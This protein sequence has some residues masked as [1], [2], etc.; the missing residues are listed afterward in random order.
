MPDLLPV[1]PDSDDD[2]NNSDSTGTSLGDDA[3]DEDEDDWDLDEDFPCPHTNHPLHWMRPTV[4]EMYDQ[5]YK[6]PWD[7]FPRG[8]AY[9]RHVLGVMKDTCPDLFRQELCMSHTTIDRLVKK[10]A[11]DPVFVNGSNNAQMPVKDQLAITLF[12]FGH[13]GNAAGLQKVATGVGGANGTISLVTRRIMTA[14]PPRVHVG[15]CSH[16]DRIR[17]GECEGAGSVAFMQRVEEWMVHGRRYT[18]GSF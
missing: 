14:V 1:D 11:D 17:E 2:D 4:K 9:L 13:S 8:P 6:M 18:G 15:G 5:R 7:T 12:R 16:A 10:L 3:H